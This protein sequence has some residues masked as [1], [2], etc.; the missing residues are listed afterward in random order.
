[1]RAGIATLSLMVL[2]TGCAAPVA[3]AEPDLRV[4]AHWQPWNDDP[5]PHLMLVIDNRGS[6]PASVGP[7][8]VDMTLSGPVD[9]GQHQ[10]PAY[11]GDTPFSRPIEP[12]QRVIL[13]LHPREDPEGRFGL[14]LDHVWGTPAPPQPG[15]YETCLGNS[16]AKARLGEG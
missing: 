2:A 6:A 12:A 4:A 3:F 15:D 13:A 9:G 1:M 11:W 7:G 10:I 5:L 8:G 14:A 16:C